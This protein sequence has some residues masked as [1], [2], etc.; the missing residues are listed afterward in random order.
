VAAGILSEPPSVLLFFLAVPD[1]QRFPVGYLDVS[2][3]PDDFSLL[4][5]VSLNSKIFS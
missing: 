3:D 5:K 1:R 4:G 2:A